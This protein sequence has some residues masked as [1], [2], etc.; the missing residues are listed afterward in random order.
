M[1]EKKAR[2][3]EFEISGDK[4]VERLKQIVHGGNIRRITIKNEKGDTLIEVPLT[5]GIVGAA[6]LPV[7]AAIGAIAAMVAK[8]KIVIVKTE[9]E[10]VGDTAD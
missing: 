4:L 3:E 9:E 1:S 10:K 2:T 5:L 8:L 6:L 7:W